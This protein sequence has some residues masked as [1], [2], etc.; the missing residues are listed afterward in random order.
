MRSLSIVSEVPEVKTPSM[1]AMGNW[2]GRIH[3]HLWYNQQGECVIVEYYR[4][5]FNWHSSKM[6][7]MKDRDSAID[8]LNWQ[9][10]L[11]LERLKTREVTEETERDRCE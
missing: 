8:W 10:K 7:I 5:F 6:W 11:G 4:G 2:Q 9:Y 1:K 3:Y